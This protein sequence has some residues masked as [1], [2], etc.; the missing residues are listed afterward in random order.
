MDTVLNKASGK[1]N[2]PIVGKIAEHGLK[3]NLIEVAFPNGP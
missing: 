2:S 1:P 3:C